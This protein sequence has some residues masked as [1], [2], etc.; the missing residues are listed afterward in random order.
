M[1]NNKK[2][3]LSHSARSDYQKCPTYFYWLRVRRVIAVEL[4]RNIKMDF[5]DGIHGGLD[6]RSKGNSLENAIKEFGS[7]FQ[8]EV[9]GDSQHTIK[10]GELILKDYYD[11]YQNEDLVYVNFE[12]MY[13]KD[14]GDFLF[15][16]KIDKEIMDGGKKKVLDH[17]TMR[18]FTMLEPNLKPNGQ[19]TG[20][21]YMKREEGIESLIVDAILKPRPLKT[22]PMV[23]DFIRLETMRT[24]R[25]LK[26]W[27]DDLVIE[28]HE[29]LERIEKG[30]WKRNE[31][32]YGACCSYNEAC[33]YRALC[34]LNKE[35]GDIQP[36]GAGYVLKPERKE[37]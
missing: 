35:L 32:L 30:R 21:I 14:F 18:S 10:M 37:Q 1:N 4:V 17:K 8:G 26:H 16:A 23:T 25:E 27:E 12:Q 19:F 3:R 5:G 34:N 7:R 15:V 9:E 31:D 24:E 20:Y 11:R 2:L 36:V 33:Q 6:E 22:K 28:A 29:I 13:E